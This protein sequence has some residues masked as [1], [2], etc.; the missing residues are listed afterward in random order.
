MT[1]H[2]DLAAGRWESFSLAEQLANVGSEV[3]RSIVAWEAHRL[4]RF[5]K[6]LARALELLDLRPGP[7]PARSATN[8]SSLPR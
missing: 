2:A 5:E 7:T 3:D 8:S 6:A 4:D 1:T